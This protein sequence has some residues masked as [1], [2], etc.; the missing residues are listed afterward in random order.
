MFQDEPWDTHSP[1]LETDSPKQALARSRWAWCALVGSIGVTL[2][3]VGCGPYPENTFEPT[4]D[5]AHDISNLFLFIIY[6]A[7]VV[8]ILTFGLIFYA[9]FRFR[10]KP[11]DPRPTG[12]HGNTT[13]EIIWTIIPALI[14]AAIAV[15]TVGLIFSSQADAPPDSLQ[16]AAS[17]HMWWF[18]L[19]YPDKKIVTANEMHIPLGQDVNIKIDSKDVLHSFWPPK[20]AG[21]RDMIPNHAN[22][23]WFKAQKTGTY[24]GE[25]TEFCG[26]SHAHMNFEVMVDTPEQFDAWV[27]RQ[28]APA[29]APSDPQATKGAQLFLSSG[30][31][32][33]HTIDGTDAKGQIGPNLTHVASRNLIAAATL[34]NNAASLKQWIRNPADTKPGEG[35][36]PNTMPPFAGNDDDLNA[37]VA[38]VQTLK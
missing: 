25:C 18:E 11:G 32:G 28:Q 9:A 20:L 16:V 37:L 7:V 26:P 38:Y 36:F 10:G 12:V 2:F 17:G 35:Q 13:I 31:A 34:E 3:L 6:L 22:Y 1:L 5:Y 27:K 15:P 33:C 21:K 23:I 8:F 4:S 30:C 19:Q 29:T 24:F 14:L